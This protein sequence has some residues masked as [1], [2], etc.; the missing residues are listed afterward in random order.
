MKTKYNKIEFEWN[1][2]WWMVLTTDF[3]M[4]IGY[5]YYDKGFCDICYHA[6]STAILDRGSL[7]DIANFIDELKY[8]A[9]FYDTQK[10]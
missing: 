10:I 1:G 2:N 5:I 9:K 8:I 7:L 4:I 3:K 6:E